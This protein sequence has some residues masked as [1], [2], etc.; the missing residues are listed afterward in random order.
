MKK[1]HSLCIRS[2]LSR[3]FVL[4]LKK[5]YTKTQPSHAFVLDLALCV[6]MELKVWAWPFK[7]RGRGI[8][9]RALAD[10]LQCFCV[11][12]SEIT[13]LTRLKGQGKGKLNINLNSSFFLVHI[14]LDSCAQPCFFLFILFWHGDVMLI[15]FL[16][17]KQSNGTP[18]ENRAV[19]WCSSLLHGSCQKSMFSM[20]HISS[21]WF[22]VSF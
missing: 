6:L 18:T 5:T 11:A 9:A 21:G 14:Y 10:W 15:F 13:G 19:C 8:S 20:N 3:L 1:N 4:I 2:E 17:G 12:V 16:S 22:R 7:T